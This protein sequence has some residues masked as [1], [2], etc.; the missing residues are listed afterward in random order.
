MTELTQEAIAQLLGV[1]EATQAQRKH[2][3]AECE[4]CPLASRPMAPTTGPANSDA[5]MVSRSPGYHEAM[6]GKPFTG[7][8]GKVLDHFLKENGTSRDEIR[9][10]NVVLC[11]PN[12]PKVPKEAIKACKPRLDSELQ[13][14]GLI[15]AA[16]AEAI[17]AVFGK[18]R[19][20]QSM[21]GC[22]HELQ[23]GQT[24]VCTN[25]PALV[26]RDDGVFPNL[27]SDFRR[28]FNPPPP[29]TLPKV[30]VIEDVQEAK[31]YITHLIT[32]HKGILAA[33]IETRGGLRKDATL[34]SLQFSDSG[35]SATV[36]GEREGLWEDNS[37]IADYLRPL[38]ASEVHHFVYHNG[39]FDTKVL[40]HSYD[41]PAR[42]DQDTILLSAALDSRPGTHSLEYLLMNELDWPKYDDD[43]IA[44]IKKT[45]IVTDYDKFYTYAGMDVA[46]TYQL[47][48]YLKDKALEDG[49]F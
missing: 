10:T 41:L 27:R 2:P 4:K 18:P 19:S 42:I 26:I 34:I 33:D 40:R 11:A 7:P 25:N 28:A 6:S 44:K 38:I 14:A 43:E 45:G 24:V 20:I 13:D 35:V 29:P 17:A 12:G 48:H 36:L 15:I 9:L 32:D 16:G 8:S 31:D 49:T 1:D 23:S 5:I 21:R 30:K 37:F 22:R 3:L 39:S 47:F 46:G